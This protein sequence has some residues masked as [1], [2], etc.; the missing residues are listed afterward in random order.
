[1]GDVMAPEWNLEDEVT[2]LAA[3]ALKRHPPTPLPVFPD[4]GDPPSEQ[5]Q[6]NQDKD[7]EALD[8]DGDEDDLEPPSY[9]PY[10][11]SSAT[12]CLAYI[13][14]IMATHT[15]A[16]APS[17]QNRVEPI[18]WQSILNALAARGNT[19]FMDAQIMQNVSSRLQAVYGEPDK[20]DHESSTVL[21][22]FTC[23]VRQGVH[24]IQII[25]AAKKKLS[26]LMTAAEASI[27]E[28]PPVLSEKRRHR[29]IGSRVPPKGR[30][31]GSDEEFNKKNWTWKKRKGKAPELPHDE[32]EDD[33]WIDLDRGGATSPPRRSK[34]K[35]DTVN[36]VPQ[37][38]DDSLHEKGG[39]RVPE[40][41]MPLPTRK[42]RTRKKA[43]PVGEV[44]MELDDAPHIEGEGE[45]TIS[46]TPPAKRKR[47]KKS[48]VKTA[49]DIPMELDDPPHEE[50]AE[51]E[52]ESVHA[53]PGSPASPVGRKK[54][55]KKV[56]PVVDVP[57]EPDDPQQE[58][59]EGG[60]G[61]TEVESRVNDA[62]TTAQ[63]EYK[64]KG[65]S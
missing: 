50:D 6:A 17:L 18:H 59:E 33:E 29:E 60:D 21:L 57:S 4:D 7:D 39:P 8:L 53:V 47:K 2:L 25:A 49:V 51:M 10:L 28:V 30:R 20:P 1:M 22:M 11:V 46:L 38:L 15:P 64:G 27:F 48:V 65:D 16:R 31:R 63:A 26:D 37:E 52:A 44:P 35:R 45:V 43:N 34:R 42:R 3:Q 41:A 13:L 12:E 55:R 61:E 62:A 19:R 54:A 9:I 32:E 24:R 58:F 14:D 36:Y 5:R 23:V 56:D 40:G